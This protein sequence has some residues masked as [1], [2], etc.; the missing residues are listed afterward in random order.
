MNN[1]RLKGNLFRSGGFDCID[2]LPV[3]LN[4]FDCSERIQLLMKKRYTLLTYA[5]FLIRDSSLYEANA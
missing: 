4:N 5:G 1:V 2:C 3:S